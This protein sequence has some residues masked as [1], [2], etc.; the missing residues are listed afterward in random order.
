MQD[1]RYLEFIVLRLLGY[2]CVAVRYIAKLANAGCQHGVCSWLSV[3]ERLE[4]KGNRAV[5][6]FTAGLRYPL[7]ARWL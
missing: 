6:R 2:F 3:S 7:L 1:R 4:R 5:N